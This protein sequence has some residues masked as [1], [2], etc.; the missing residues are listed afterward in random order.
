MTD[1]QTKNAFRMTVQQAAAADMAEI[2]ALTEQVFA[3]EQAIPRELIPI[4]AEQEPR[5]WYIRQ[6]EPAWEYEPPPDT[7][8]PLLIFASAARL[9]AHR[10]H[11]Y[12]HGDRSE[13]RR[14]YL[15]FSKPFP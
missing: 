1:L 13:I 7:A 12:P 14:R 15:H 10:P 6:A 4:P 5:W 11:K 2:L 9:P 3:N 8:F